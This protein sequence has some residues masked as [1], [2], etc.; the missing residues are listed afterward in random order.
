MLPMPDP[1]PTAT[2]TY[3][4][5]LLRPEQTWW[6]RALDVQRPYRRLFQALAPGRV[7]DIGCGVGRMLMWAEPG[8]VGLDHNPHS[9]RAARDRGLMA[10]LP[11]EFLAS[12]DATPAGFDMVVLG[13]V[14]EHLTP[15]QGTDLLRT[16]LPFLRRG[17][18]VLVITPQEAGYRSDATHVTFLDA[19]AVSRLLASVGVHVEQ[20]RSFPFPRMAG[21][22]FRYNEFVTVGRWDG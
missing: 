15:D 10:Y 13:H 4:A 9:V 7:L 20:A 18:R 5:R 3:T 14:L 22:L 17:G 2:D 1:R 11:D 12:P 16:Y 19:D 8:S 21:R 6:K